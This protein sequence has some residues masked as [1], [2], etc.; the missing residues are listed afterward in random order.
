MLVVSLEGT[1]V[2]ETDGRGRSVE[3]LCCLGRSSAGSIRAERADVLGS[4]P[5]A[6]RS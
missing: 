2:L 1:Y 6:I 5:S 4:A 3:R